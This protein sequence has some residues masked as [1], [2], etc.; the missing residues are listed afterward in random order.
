MGRR[1]VGPRVPAKGE[2]EAPEGRQLVAPGFSPGL[3]ETGPLK[4]RRGD[5]TCGSALWRYQ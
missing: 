1:S 3:E 4:P 2:F 5:T